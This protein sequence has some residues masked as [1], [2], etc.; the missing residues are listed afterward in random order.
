MLPGFD[1]K[2]H[3]GQLVPIIQ[4]RFGMHLGLKVSLG[5]QELQESLL[6]RRKLRFV[7]G[8]FVGK[9]HDLQKSGV[10]K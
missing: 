8:T 5:M 10:G 1:V 4:L 9:V 3:V 6:G 7:I 2:D